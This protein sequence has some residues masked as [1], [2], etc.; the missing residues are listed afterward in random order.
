MIDKKIYL[1]YDIK[2]FTKLNHT[3][4]ITYGDQQRNIPISSSPDTCGKISA[5]YTVTNF[6]RAI[7]TRVLGTRTIR[8]PKK[9]RFAMQSALR[10]VIYDYASDLPRAL[11]I[12]ERALEDQITI[13]KDAY[14][15]EPVTESKK[16]DFLENKASSQDN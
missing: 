5:L 9:R 14:R 16:P 4:S 11:S 10:D 15:R 12:A 13:L 2:M 1:N 3:R 7:R 8:N 6:S